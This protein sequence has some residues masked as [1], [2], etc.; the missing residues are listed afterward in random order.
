MRYLLVVYL[1]VVLALIVILF[2]ST[3]HCQNV[4]SSVV[5][6]WQSPD[7]PQHA[8]AQPMRAEQ[9]LSDGSGITYGH[10]ERPMWECYKPKDEQVSL[11]EIARKYREQAETK[12]KVVYENQ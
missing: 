4:R 11:G 3:G 8:D 12:T 1:V 5:N 10:G 6:P 9:S 2:G 7:H